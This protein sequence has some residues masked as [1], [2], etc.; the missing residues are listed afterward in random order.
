MS[1]YADQALD[2]TGE[3]IKDGVKNAAGMI[4][5]SGTQVTADQ[6]LID[7]AASYINLAPGVDADPN[8]IFGLYDALSELVAETPEGGVTL[9]MPTS[10]MLEKIKPWMDPIV[11]IGPLILAL[12]GY[13]AFQKTKNAIGNVGDKIGGTAGD[14]KDGAVNAANTVKDVAGEGIDK[15]KD[16]FG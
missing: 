5:P 9:K 8:T 12:K 15:V 1:Q 13:E 2:K 6:S 4:V 7:Q 11:D 3:M 14:V 10:K 16:I